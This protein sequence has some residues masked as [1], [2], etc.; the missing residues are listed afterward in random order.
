MAEELA[1]TLLLNEVRFIPSANPPHK[2]APAVSAEHRAAMVQLAIANN[3]TFKFDGRELARTGASYTFDTL[4]SLREELGAHASIT[5][6]MG[7]DAF[8]KLNTW[9][10]WEELLSLCHICL[11]ARPHTA[12]KRA[13]GLSKALESH[14]QAHYTENSEDLLEQ[15]CGHIT[16]QKMTSLDI[17]STAIRNTL[18]CKHSARYLLPDDL[19]EYINLH[20][21]YNA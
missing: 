18:R 12:S 16:M 21:L 14:L 11:V 5:L 9:H 19:L 8:T 1:E 4:L 13:E 7:N 17:S 2:P 15:A 3:P 10:R 20:Q 6:L